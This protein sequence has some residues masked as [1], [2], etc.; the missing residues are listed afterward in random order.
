MRRLV[1]GF[2]PFQNA[3]DAY[4]V[5]G[6]AKVE[7][8]EAPLLMYVAEPE[9]AAELAE[10]Y[11]QEGLEPTDLRFGVWPDAMPVPIRHY[12]SKE[13]YPRHRDRWRCLPH[14]LRQRTQD[15]ET[16][17]VHL[18]VFGGRQLRYG[19]ATPVERG[20]MNELTWLVEEHVR[21]VI[22]P[23]HGV[24]THS[25]GKIPTMHKHVVGR[26]KREDGA[27]NWLERKLVDLS[28]RQA[29]RERVDFDLVPGRREEIAKHIGTTLRR[30]VD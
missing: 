3:W 22:E 8:T 6:L 4:D 21:E 1:E 5:D 15:D 10:K 28:V 16:V 2:D 9:L 20:V 7:Q 30:Y 25:F 23:E 29:M 13:I 17:G 19:N 12:G 18:N 26:E 11:A 14:W 24:S 27:K